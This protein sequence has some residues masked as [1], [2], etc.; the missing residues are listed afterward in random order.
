[1][2][3][4]HCNETNTDT[5]KFCKGCGQKLSPIASP[6]Q[7]RHVNDHSG[8][9]LIGRGL[10]RPL[11]IV[12]TVVAV[13]VVVLVVR[14][15]TPV[16]S[17][18]SFC[19][20]YKKEATTLHDKYDRAASNAKA[21]DSL[22]SMINGLGTVAQAPGDLVVL[23]DRLDKVAPDDIQPDVEAVR[24][25]LKKQADAAGE[26]ASNPLGALFSGLINGL[27]NMGSFERVNNY[28][29]ENCEEGGV[30]Q[31]QEDTSVMTDVVEK[32]NILS[33]DGVEQ[34][35]LRLWE[36]GRSGIVA[37]M[38][39]ELVLI[40]P[41]TYT[42][43]AR[44]SLPAHQ[45]RTP[46]GD[47]GK[48]YTLEIDT[49]K[50]DVGLSAF[51]ADFRRIALTFKSDTDKDTAGR[52]TGSSVG[53]YDLANE[54]VTDITGLN[55][56][57]AVGHGSFVVGDVKPL[58]NLTDR[59]ILKFERGDWLSKIPWEYN[60]VTG[61]FSELGQITNSVKA[62]PPSKWDE[63]YTIQIRDLAEAGNDVIKRTSGGTG[64]GCSPVEFVNTTTILC[65][66]PNTGK[67]KL[68]DI[69]NIIEHKTL[70]DD[71]TDYNYRPGVLHYEIPDPI[72]LDGTTGKEYIISPD[73]TTLVSSDGHTLYST[74][75]IN[76]TTQVVGE[77]ASST[78]SSFLEWR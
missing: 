15:M 72:P 56:P 26:M 58:F 10:V 30:A 48:S 64:L 59:N 21:D 9:P 42:I 73:H 2:H 11:H 4:P 35:S 31:T 47:S 13:L 40:D 57:S 6:R 52:P 12:G 71:P 54:E 28:I 23:F 62:V 25:S 24:D 36:Q 34:D 17:V 1:M 53:Y 33:A 77:F 44:H 32:R 61:A 41:S 63:T 19:A 8:G 5:A 16:R 49:S 50:G 29:I 68:L 78:L 55:P 22:S 14:H 45:G 67:L 38:N 65:A 18:E 43:I 60:L 70:T 3:C 20:T 27:Q 46:G 51:D 7:H 75:L 39:G 69:S 66:D 37:V 74:D 76:N